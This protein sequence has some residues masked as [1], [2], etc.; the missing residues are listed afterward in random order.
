MWVIQELGTQGCDVDKIYA[1]SNLSGLNVFDAE[2]L[3]NLKS[4]VFK[5]NWA[6]KLSF[7]YQP[8]VFKYFIA[9]LCRFWLQFEKEQSEIFI[10]H[11]AL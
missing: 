3:V 10:L 6:I 1:L 8:V 5:T 7:L 9:Q 4:K 2:L 11:L